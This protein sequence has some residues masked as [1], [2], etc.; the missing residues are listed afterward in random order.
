MIQRINEHSFWYNIKHLALIIVHHNND[1]TSAYNNIH[2]NY[3]AQYNSWLISPAFSGLRK[4]INFI[5]SFPSLPTISWTVIVN[6][7]V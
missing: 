1:I 3:Y 6:E 2:G 7:I 5:I 4:Y